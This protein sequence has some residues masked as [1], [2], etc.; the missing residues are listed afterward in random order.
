MAEN[1]E[2]T[3]KVVIITG[4]A[5]GIG[6]G[7]AARLARYGASIVIASRSESTGAQ[8]VQDLQKIVGV[9]AGQVVHLP[10]DVANEDSVAATIAKAVERFGRLD[11]VINNAVFPGDFKLL[12]DEPGETFDRV[13]Q[14]NVNGVFYGMKHAILQFQSQGAKQGDNYSIINISSGATRDTGMTMAP[15]IASKLAVEG[16]TQAGA[17]EYARA[18]IRVNTLLFG[19]FNTEKSQALHEAMPQ[20]RDKNAAK[21]HIGRFGDPEHDAGEAAAFLI[22]SRSSFITGT[23]IF[24]DGGM[25]L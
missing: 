22:S 4:G 25:C 15:Y 11:A 5:E 21:H 12:A 23:T 6:K 20:V 13:M 2:L 7:M 19:V 3:G 9:E 18:G 8:A 17:L 1:R 14:T 16:L 10:T 24:V